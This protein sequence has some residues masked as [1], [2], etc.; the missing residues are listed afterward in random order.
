MTGMARVASSC[1][2]SIVAWRP[3][4]PG[5][6]MS[7]RI[8]L[9][10]SLRASFRPASAFVAMST[11][12]PTAS[13]RM[14]VTVVWAGLSSMTRTV[15]MSRPRSAAGHGPPDFVPDAAVVERAL[16]HDRRHVAI[17]RVALL[18]GDLLGGDDQDRNASGVGSRAERLDHVEAGHLRHHQ[19][20]HDAVPQLPPRDL[21]RLPSAARAQHGAGQALEANGDELDRQ[22]IVVDH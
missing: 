7:I 19:V 10:S 4:M 9:G 6:W 5:S 21:D 12:W 3:S 1:L 17:Q 22:G 16:G 11:V 8:R 18:H 15:A 20:E 13:R 14:T 2:R